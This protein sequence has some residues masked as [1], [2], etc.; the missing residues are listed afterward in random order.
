[1]TDLRELCAW[2]YL[3]RQ[4]GLPDDAYLEDQVDR[5]VGWA[6]D[7]GLAVVLTMH[8]YKWSEWFTGGVGAPAWASADLGYT[9]DDLGSQQAGCDFWRDQRAPD[10]VTLKDHLASVWSL[11]A[12]H[13]ADNSTVIG[14]DLFNEPPNIGCIRGGIH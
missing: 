4:P 2:A 10:G 14:L 1:M 8:Q 5:V 13:Y 12:A 11:V 7:H 9:D 3:E 6:G